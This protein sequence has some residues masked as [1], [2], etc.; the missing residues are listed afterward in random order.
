LKTK[1]L[2]CASEREASERVRELCIAF[3]FRCV[4]RRFRRRSVKVGKKQSLSN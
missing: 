1:E 4:C 3:A 2:L